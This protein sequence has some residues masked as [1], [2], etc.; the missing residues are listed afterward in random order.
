MSS[1]A[2]PFRRC[3]TFPD[4]AYTDLTL[5]LSI[6]LTRDFIPEDGDVALACCWPGLAMADPQRAIGALVSCALDNTAS[7]HDQVATLALRAAVTVARA[8]LADLDPGTV[9]R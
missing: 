4:E 9:A 3:S 7:G 1:P 6:A 2:A 5:S 8:A